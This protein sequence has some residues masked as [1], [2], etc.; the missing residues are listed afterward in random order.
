MPP[1]QH[2]V[3]L[4]VPLTGS[5][6]PVSTSIANAARLALRD[7]GNAAIGLTVYDSG[8]AGASAAATRAIAEGNQL[9]LGPLLSTEA[10]AVGPVARRSR[11]PVIAFSNDRAAAGDG[12][13]LMGTVPDLA[14]DRIVRFARS[15]GAVRFAALLPANLYGER[16]G[17]SFRMALQRSGGTLVT[18]Q[19]Y[20]GTAAGLRSAAARIRATAAID[21]VL[22][23]DDSGIAAIAAPLVGR[24]RRILGTELWGNDRDIWRT[25]ALR[26]AW[27][28][29]VPNANFDALVG[30]YRQVYD[31]VPY[32]LASVGYDAVLL[33]VRAAQD[34]RPG[35]PF[36]QRTLLDPDG[37][38][39]VDGIFRFGPDGVAERALE[40][41]EVRAGTT[42]ILSP[43]PTSFRQ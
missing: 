23:A 11:V 29:A 9:I 6:G 10:R 8:V 20:G 43:A 19:T 3:A 32:R 38:G 27:Y 17:L 34:W 40:V 12:V 36:P 1:P 28:A 26:G 33:T 30:R 5:E 13:F 37:F 25:A 22:I 24:G 15:R 31:R 14:I 39:G 41:R 18:A 7:S 35:R 16:A 2:K 21:A 42:A 4:L